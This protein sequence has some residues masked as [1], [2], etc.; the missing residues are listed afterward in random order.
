MIREA[1]QREL[2]SLDAAIVVDLAS[3]SLVPAIP[4][5]YSLVMPITHDVCW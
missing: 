4:Y 3:G 2:V 1:Y 5:S